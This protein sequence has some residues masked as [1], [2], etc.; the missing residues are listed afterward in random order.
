MSHNP[1]AFKCA[2]DYSTPFL[3][4]APG[5]LMKFLRIT[6]TTLL[7]LYSLGCTRSTKP[8][9][10][11]L[12]KLREKTYARVHEIFQEA[13]FYK[14]NENTTTP[15][16]FLLAPLIVQAA[17]D[18]NA[19]ASQ[20]NHIAAIEAEEKGRLIFNVSKPTIYCDISTATL[21]GENHRQVTYVWWYSSDK[22]EHQSLHNAV[23]RGY[24]MTLD[25]DGFPMI[26]EVLGN[27]S[28]LSVLFVSKTLEEAAAKQFGSPLAERRFSIERS[29]KDR[30]KVIVARVLDD[31][32]QPMGPFVYLS[33]EDRTINTIICRCMPSQIRNFIDNMNYEIQPLAKLGNLD[34]PAS[35]A[36]LPHRQNEINDPVWLQQSLRLPKM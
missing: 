26:W 16:L 14:P 27:R 7:A 19:Q 36:E 15:E 33:A 17:V 2:K 31:G 35:V 24:R 30:P 25:L 34:L 23:W 10:D 22:L 11:P 13:I 32:P 20:M 3:P 18:G 4:V 21:H 5:D 29:I 6:I 9:N 28:E 8:A 1:D 12:S